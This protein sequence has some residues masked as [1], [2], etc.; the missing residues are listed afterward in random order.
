[1]TNSN[2]TKNFPIDAAYYFGRKLSTQKKE[3]SN[4][5]RKRYAERIKETID[6]LSE[7]ERESGSWKAF[8]SL[9]Y[10]EVEEADDGIY[11]LDFGDQKVTVYIENNQY[12]FFVPNYSGTLWKVFEVTNGNIIPCVGS[13]CMSYESEVDADTFGLFRVI[14]N[15]DIDFANLPAK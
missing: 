4:E 9:H 13:E 14:K 1:M 5:I 2:S 6:L 10:T 8:P 7:E 12:D 15:S 3:G 11:H